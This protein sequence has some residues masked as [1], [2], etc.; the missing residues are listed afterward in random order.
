MPSITLFTAIKMSLRTSL[1]YLRQTRLSNCR[2][3]PYGRVVPM[4]SEHCSSNVSSD[5]ESKIYRRYFGSRILL[6][7]FRC[8]L[9]LLPRK[10]CLMT[11][12]ILY[13][14]CNF[15]TYIKYIWLKYRNWEIKVLY[16]VHV[17]VYTT[18]RSS[19]TWRALISLAPVLG[20]TPN[21]SLICCWKWSL[22]E[23]Y[24]VVSFDP[25][26]YMVR[27]HLNPWMKVLVQSFGLIA[28]R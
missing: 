21:K 20:Y 8:L 17:V 11:R 12:S 23:L 7:Q 26:W 1:C 25:H 5:T 28:L 2:L 18:W 22:N 14:M 15:C 4:D 6:N 27:L 24:L 16:E 9:R 10:R 19:I 13:R 3:D